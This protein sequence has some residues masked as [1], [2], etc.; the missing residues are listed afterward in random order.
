[1]FLA[2]YVRAYWHIIQNTGF[3]VLSVVL[4]PDSGSF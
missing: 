3:K 2:D 4:V 1:M